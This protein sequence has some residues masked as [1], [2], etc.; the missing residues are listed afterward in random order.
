MRSHKIELFFVGLFSLSLVLVPGA[1][2]TQKQ[3]TIIIALDQSGSM[4]QSDPDKLRIEAAGLLAATENAKDQV[5]VIAF[6]D[7]ARWLQ[8]PI[9][10]DRFDF[11]L[12]DKAGASDA[13]TAFTPV[14]RAVEEYLIAQPSSFFQDNN[15]SLVLL[16]DGRSDPAD[17]LADADRSAALSIAS[18][19]AS[20]LKIYTIA[21]GDNLDRDFLERLARSSNGLSIQVVSAADLPDAFLRVAARAAALPVYLRTSSSGSLKWA[22]TP[23]R[24]VAVFTGEHGAS[25]QLD[26]KALY[27]SAHVAVA[28]Q[29]PASRSTKLAWSGRGR[30]FLCIQEPLSLSPEGDFPVALLTDAP[31]PLTLTLQSPHGPLKDAFF[32]EN[33]NAALELVGPDSETVPLYK[34]DGANRFTGEIEARS[35]GAFRAYA[36]LE[37]PY[38]EVETFLG[39]LTASVLPIAIPKQISAGVFDPLPRAWFAKKLAIRSL[40]PV[41]VV[42]LRF[43]SKGLPGQLSS[44]RVA[45]GQSAEFRMPLDGALGL[46]HVV[47]YSATWS[48]GETE[49]SRHGTFRVLVRQMTPGE[50]LRDKWP[51]AAALLLLICALASTIWK[52]WPRPLQADLIVRQNGTQVLRL[53]LPSQ[54]RTRTLHVSES[55][56][57]KSSGSSSAVIAGPQSRKLLSLQSTRRRGRWTIIARPGAAHASAQQARKWSEID[58]RA[59]HVPVFATEDGTIQINVLYS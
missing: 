1:R 15:I 6:G 47:E 37:S 34:Q 56:T 23:Q 17:K 29:D 38:G 24:V 44:M 30:A 52:F 53:K 22:G 2:A 14:L 35:A 43:S 40:L 46:M 51:W 25:V 20:R 55:E 12:L 18:Q 26:G 39:D 13:H 32:L 57:G 59:V 7:A 58:L 19:N 42:S 16:T 31:H 21:L 50:L 36:T 10:R 33:A 28:E 27:R 9:E 3:R 48:D 41:G 5:G 11:K 4:V 45:P 8:K 49:V 54:L